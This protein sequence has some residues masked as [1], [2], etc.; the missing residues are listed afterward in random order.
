M[1]RIQLRQATEP[2]KP[3][4]PRDETNVIQSEMMGV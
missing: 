3:D 4:I 2:T 1:E